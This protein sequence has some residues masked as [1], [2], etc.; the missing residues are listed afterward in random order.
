M[1]R[2]TKLIKVLWALPNTL[3]GLA[4]GGIG[5]CTGGKLQICR[6]CMEFS[7]GMVRWFVRHLPLG[8][9]TLAIT[10][11]HTILGQTPSGLAIARDHEHVHVAQYERWGPFFLPAYFVCSVWLWMIGRDA[12]RDNPF[13]VEAFAHDPIPVRSSH[14]NS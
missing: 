2:L 5:L 13:E 3:L 7:G 4:L 8:D 9:A 10:L 12:Y 6:G 1:Q 11:G 14:E